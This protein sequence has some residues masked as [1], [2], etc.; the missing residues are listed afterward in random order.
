MCADASGK[1]RAEA[2]V[3]A[4]EERGS[5]S[6]LRQVCLV[7][8]AAEKADAIGEPANAVGGPAAAE[9]AM[10]IFGIGSP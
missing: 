4:K 2:R 10:Q 7:A 1:E 3:F 9:L 5:A 8:F 6:H